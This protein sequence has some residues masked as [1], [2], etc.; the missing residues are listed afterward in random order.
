MAP[1]GDGTFTVKVPGVSVGP[2]W[3]RA[4]VTV[5]FVVPAGYPLASPDCFWTEPGLALEHGGAPQNTGQT[6]GIGVEAGWLWFSWHP[7]TWAAND[8]NF[9]TYLNVIRRRFADPQ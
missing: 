3:N 2:G 6:P 1:N 7:A 8:S 9:E 4:S 5:A